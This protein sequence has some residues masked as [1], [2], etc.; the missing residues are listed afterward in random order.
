MVC[1]YSHFRSIPKRTVLFM[2]SHFLCSQKNSS[3]HLLPFHLSPKE[4]FCSPTPISSVPKR[5]VLFTFS[6]FICSQKKTDLFTYSHF[7]LFPKN[8]YC[9]PTPISSVPK[10]TDLFTCS[11]FICSQKNSSVRLLLFHLFPKEQICS[12]S[13]ISSV[14][15]R[16]A[17]PT[18]RSKKII[19]S[20]KIQ[21]LNKQ[22]HNI[23][24]MLLTI[25]A[26]NYTGWYECYHK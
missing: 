9:S 22:F 19:S 2:Y 12:P 21:V 23:K 4:Q 16:T 18:I 24:Y 13:P 25:Y 17:L 15:K 14:P 20:N 6:Y 10:R 1:T 26:S 3:V 8:Q 11:Y 5:T 7:R